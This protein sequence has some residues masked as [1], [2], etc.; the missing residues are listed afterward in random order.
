MINNYKSSIKILEEVKKE[1]D[2]INKYLPSK[3][4]KLNETRDIIKEKRREFEPKL[5]Y[6][7]SNISNSFSL[8][9]TKVGS[10]GAIKLIKAHLYKEWRIEIMV[11]FRDNGLLRKLDSHV[12]S[13]GERAVSTIMYMIALQEFTNSPFRLVDEINQGMDQR[14]ERIVH[15]AMVEVACSENT[16]QYFL[17]TPKLLTNLYYN[18]NMRI[19]CVMAGPLVPD[20]SKNEEL[21]HLGETTNYIL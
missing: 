18:E 16:L 12:Q 15:K 9:F 6:I 19:H 7:I 11:K 14:N 1:I 17:I 20:P 10:G 21:I 8:L 5:D 13:G 2:K 4:L 3:V